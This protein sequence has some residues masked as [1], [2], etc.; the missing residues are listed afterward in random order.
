MALARAL[1]ERGYEIWFETW[2]RWRD[3][4]EDLGFQFVAA[5]EYI[6]FPARGLGC[7]LPPPC[8]SAPARFG[9][10]RARFVQQW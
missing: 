10:S 7:P 8:R 4:V 5:P 9:R 6:A 2:E 1:D 3:A